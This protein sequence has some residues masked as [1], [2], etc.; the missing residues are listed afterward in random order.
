MNDEGEIELTE[1][2][3]DD[4]HVSNSYTPPNNYPYP[5]LTE[6]QESMLKHNN[7][8]GGT[9]NNNNHSDFN[10]HPDNMPRLRKPSGFTVRGNGGPRN[11]RV[12]VN[13]RQRAKDIKSKMPQVKDVNNIDKY[14]RLMF[15]LLFVIFNAWY[16][17]YYSVLS[18]M[19][20]KN[21]SE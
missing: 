19:S 10:N 7:S 4:P 18:Q 1:I 5:S 15:P 3:S 20:V 17:V 9:T 21:I 14:S 13:I 8:R 6:E 2:G 12:W 16:W 11:R